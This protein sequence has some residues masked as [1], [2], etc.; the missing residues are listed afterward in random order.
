MNILII[1]GLHGDE[2]LGIEVIKLLRN[3]PIKSVTGIFGNPS[4]ITTNTRYCDQDL[5][6]VFPGKTNGS[7]EEMRATQIMSFGENFDIIL[8][9]HNTTAINNNCSFVGS[10]GK[11]ILFDVSSFLGLNDVVIADYPCINEYL[12]NCISIEVSYSSSLCDP[13][14][15]Y[16]LI[17]KLV[18]KLTTNLSTDIIPK[19]TV[20]KHRMIG[21]ISQK[22]NYELKNW[23]LLPDELKQ[24]IGLNGEIYSLFVGEK[25]Y[26]DRYC[27]LVQKIK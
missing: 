1:G 6:R 2:T 21:K 17:Q 7:L 20:N 24:E 9:F 23:Q 11:E 3:K 25:A 5:N 12:P 27:S 22:P 10:K 14:Y 15:W 8:D 4:A 18:T 13:K 19:A 16:D 26:T